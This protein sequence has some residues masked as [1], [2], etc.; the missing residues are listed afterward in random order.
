M[1]HFISEMAST[2]MQ[3]LHKCR[4]AISYSGSVRHDC[5]V[6]QASRT[7]WQCLSS[8]VSRAQPV[9]GLRQVSRGMVPRTGKQISIPSL[10]SACFDMLTYFRLDYMVESIFDHARH[11]DYQSF[12]LGH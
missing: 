7:G 2:M 4:S 6:E 1:E 3:S 9:A 12:C 11:L 8:S 10:V 5:F